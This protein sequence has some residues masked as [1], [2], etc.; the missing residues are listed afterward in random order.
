MI[1]YKKVIQDIPI[2][3]LLSEKKAQTIYPNNLGERN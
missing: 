3:L 1:I 2:V